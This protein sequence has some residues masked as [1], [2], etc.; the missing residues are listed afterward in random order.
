LSTHPPEHLNLSSF[1]KKAKPKA[2]VERILSVMMRPAW[3]AVSTQIV[4]ASSI[5]GKETFFSR[6]KPA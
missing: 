4:K 5:L 6:F 2:L 3:K 1:N